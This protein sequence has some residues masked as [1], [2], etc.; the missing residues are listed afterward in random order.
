MKNQ[1]LNA[2]LHEFAIVALERSL[3]KSIPTNKRKNALTKYQQKLVNDYY[4]L[5]SEQMDHLISVISKNSNKND[6]ALITNTSNL[7]LTELATR[8]GYRTCEYELS[9]DQIADLFFEINANLNHPSHA[10]HFIAHN[11]WILAIGLFADL[12]YFK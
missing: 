10:I 5:S 11:S 6:N 8:L 9:D 4:Y 12:N 2:Y 3:N 1:M 7:L